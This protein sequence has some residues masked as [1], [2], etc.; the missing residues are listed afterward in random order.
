MLSG[1]DR[2]QRDRIRSVTIRAEDATL[3]EALTRCAREGGGERDALLW[4]DRA[5]TWAELE[6]GAARVARGLAS[7]GVG[8]G[9]VVALTAGCTRATSAAWTPVPRTIH[10]VEALP[11]DAEGR[12]LRSELA[13]G[14]H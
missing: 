5:W 8:V 1:P 7:Y 2:E 11:R 9:D 10:V 14:M 13:K 3:P 4:R 12:L 6:D